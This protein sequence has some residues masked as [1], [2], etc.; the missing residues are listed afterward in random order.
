MQPA[1]HPARDHQCRAQWAVPG[2]G[3]APAPSA[4]SP[5]PPVPRRHIAAPTPA[6][7]GRGSNRAVPCASPRTLG[8]SSIQ[9]LLGT[10]QSDK[11]LFEHARI[12]LREDLG[13][14]S[15]RDDQASR[16]NHDAI[17]DSRHFRHHM[18]RE[19]DGATRCRQI[20]DDAPNLSSA[21]HVEAIGR[22]VEDDVGWI[23]NERAGQRD[24]SSLAKGQLSSR[25]RCDC[26]QRKPVEH[27][28]YGATEIR[29]GET[30]QFAA[31]DQMFSNT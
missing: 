23:V 7:G 24:S 31:V 13:G 30:T 16:Q 15:G 3:F 2:R 26:C 20:A 19:H 12:G 1:P 28:I 27:E 17:A 25:P 22:L 4:P 21:Q 9:S 18:T 10:D 11:R 8:A 14:R 29:V 5:S 6:I